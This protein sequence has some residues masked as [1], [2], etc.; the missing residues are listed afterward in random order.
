MASHTEN[1]TALRRELEQVL[2]RRLGPNLKRLGFEEFAESGVKKL[3]RFVRATRDRIDVFS[4]NW[5]KGGGP[6]FLLD[7]WSSKNERGLTDLKKCI[8]TAMRDGPYHRVRPHNRMSWK[9][10]GRSWFSASSLF[11]STS[12]EAAINRVVDA[13][14]VSLAEVDIFLTTGERSKHIISL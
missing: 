11:H 5:E 3:T 13:S 2:A 14:L 6:M 12:N 4:I 8:E 10:G 9:L 1:N 7:F